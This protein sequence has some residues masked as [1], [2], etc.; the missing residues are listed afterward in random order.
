M[1][2]LL[3]RR[4]RKKIAARPVPEAWHQIVTRNA[5]LPRR[6]AFLALA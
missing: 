1:F 2:A 5:P 6:S 4:R 3:R